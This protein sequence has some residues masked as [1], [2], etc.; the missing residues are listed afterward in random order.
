[1]INV[2]IGEARSVQRMTPFRTRSN[3][4]DFEEISFLTVQDR[5]DCGSTIGI[6]P[7]GAEHECT[8][9]ESS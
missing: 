5:E 6:S 3:R 7:V 1:V 8:D 4:V 9:G 2:S